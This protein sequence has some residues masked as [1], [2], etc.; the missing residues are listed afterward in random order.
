MRQIVIRHPEILTLIGSSLNAFRDVNLERHKH[1]TS[2]TLDIPGATHFV[3]T[4]I[5]WSAL[6][7][8]RIGRCAFSMTFMTCG[9]FGNHL[10]RHN[11]PEIRAPLSSSSPL[12]G[13]RTRP[14]QFQAKEGMSNV[15]WQRHYYHPHPCPVK[16]SNLCISLTSTC[17]CRNYCQ[18]P[19]HCV[20]GRESQ[21]TQNRFS[22]SVQS[23]IH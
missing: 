3:G 15:S 5:R 17:L 1:T 19:V 4:F 14:N 23:S 6:F 12:L 13:V 11:G 18:S 9:Q 22:L 16:V 10:R 2:A 7:T 20:F 8:C 21:M